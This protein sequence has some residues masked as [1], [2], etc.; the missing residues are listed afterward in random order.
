MIKRVIT[1][2]GDLV[3]IITGD[4]SAPIVFEGE[5]YFNRNIKI[6]FLGIKIWEHDYKGNYKTKPTKYKEVI[7]TRLGF[8]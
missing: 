7:D 2:T 5:D 4:K 3:P 8:E 1:Q 6:Y